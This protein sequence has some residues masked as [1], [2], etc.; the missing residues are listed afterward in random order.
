MHGNSLI[1]FFS[2]KPWMELLHLPKEWSHVLAKWIGIIYIDKAS[3]I[4]PPK[5]F[6]IQLAWV[7]TKSGCNIQL[8]LNRFKL[9]RH[10]IKYL[11]IDKTS[12]ILFFSYRI[13]RALWACFAM[14]SKFGNITSLV[15]S[16]LCSKVHPNPPVTN[17][18]QKKVFD[19]FPRSVKKRNVHQG[20]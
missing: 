1:S 6:S 10:A 20:L 4:S 12:V 7:N 2:G 5:I 14:C 19:T 9:E 17:G 16:H 18:F 3:L 8:K 13:Y 11:F 15:S